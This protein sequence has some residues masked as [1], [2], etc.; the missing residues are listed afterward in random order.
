MTWFLFNSSIF[1]GCQVKFLLGWFNALLNY[2]GKYSS[3]IYMVGLESKVYAFDSNRSGFWQHNN[4][5]RHQYIDFKIKAF[6]F[7]FCWFFCWMERDKWTGAMISKLI[8]ILMNK[9]NA[10]NNGLSTI[11]VFFVC[12]KCVFLLSL[13][14]KLSSPITVSLWLIFYALNG[15]GKKSGQ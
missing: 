9:S 13:R 2:S 3:D 11:V 4:N 8:S 5:F 6:R 7:Y 14:S 1:A 12:K 15:I 10:I